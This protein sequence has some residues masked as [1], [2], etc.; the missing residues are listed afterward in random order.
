MSNPFVEF[1]PLPLICNILT[2]A[3]LKHLGFFPLLAGRLLN[4]QMIQTERKLIMALPAQAED[5]SCEGS[6][7]SSPIMESDAVP[8][9]ALN[10]DLKTYIQSAAGTEN[11]L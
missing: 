5:M 10:T 6:V 8:W 11:V 1:S 7:M 3:V 2:T 9:E 4:I